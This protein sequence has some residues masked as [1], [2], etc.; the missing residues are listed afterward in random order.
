MD[1]R[2][3]SRECRIRALSLSFS[4]RSITRMAILPLPSAEHKRK[5]LHLTHLRP[6]RLGIVAKLALEPLHR[7]VHAPRLRDCDIDEPDLVHQRLHSRGVDAVPLDAAHARLRMEPLAL[8][9]FV[10]EVR[11]R[12]GPAVLEAAE[13]GGQHGLQVRDVVE[14]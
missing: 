7:L 9:P 6:L 5:A 8:G 4:R 13:H 1:H 10:L 12:D 3:H 2:T 14:H 11:Q